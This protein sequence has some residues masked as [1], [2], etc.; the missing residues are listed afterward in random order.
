ML[1]RLLE[2]HSLIANVLAAVPSES[3]I[4]AAAMMLGPSIDARHA[5]SGTLISPRL[6]SR[7]SLALLASDASRPHGTLSKLGRL[8]S[9]LGLCEG[10]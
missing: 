10:E 5:A 9:A 2:K 1:L 4:K 3:L 8:L 6:L 7:K